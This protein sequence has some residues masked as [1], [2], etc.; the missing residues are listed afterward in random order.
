V[1][2]WKDISRRQR[3]F[4]TSKGILYPFGGFFWRGGP[5]KTQAGSLKD[6][7]TQK[8]GRSLLITP[9]GGIMK[10]ARSMSFCFLVFV[11]FG[12][13]SGCCCRSYNEPY[14]TP[15]P[16]PCSITGGGFCAGAERVV[17]TPAIG[18]PLSGYSGRRLGFPD[19]DPSDYHTYFRP[20]EGELDSLYARSLVLD[21]GSERVCIVTFDGCASD[22][23]VMD[24][25]RRKAAAQGFS[26]PKEKVLFCASHTHSGPGAMINKRLWKYLA[27]DLC[28]NR[29]RE[30]FTE[31]IA[32]SM[33]KAEQNLAPARIGIGTVPLAGVTRNRRAGIS[34]HLDVSDVDTQLG[35]IRVDN[36]D[37][38]PLATVWNYAIHGTSYGDD[39][40]KYS[41]DNMGAVSAHVEQN[42]GGVALFINGSEGD[43]AP[44]LM[45]SD[46]RD[47]IGQAIKNTRGSIATISSVDLETAYE[48]VNFGDPRIDASLTRLRSIT[49]GELD[50]LEFLEYYGI[51]PGVTFTMSSSWVENEFRFQAIRIGK[52]LL[53]SVPGEPIYTLGKMIKAD[54]EAMGYD[55]VFICSLANNHMGYI[56]TRQEYE[57]VCGYEGFATFFGPTTGEGVINA[58]HRVADAIKP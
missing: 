24:L 29:V 34:N 22:G 41:P 45:I 25:A 33:V 36:L 2:K 13:T 27:A 55:T 16:T 35:I 8:G 44:A 53:S 37:G 26:I 1:E 18:V 43:A 3:E 40:L 14:S 57:E 21:N 9:G 7:G 42:V 49:H 56:T 11:A 54:A 10:K 15:S 32:D 38:T 6:S 5:A 46:I 58:C 50:F 4:T 28:V 30:E 17:I 31:K 12:L 20:S 47:T 51:N 23:E 52:T 19:L 48:I 39:N